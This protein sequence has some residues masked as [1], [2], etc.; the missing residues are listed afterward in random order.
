[1]ANARGCGTVLVVLQG[2][3]SRYFGDF[4]GY[5]F[6]TEQSDQVSGTGHG[7]IVQRGS[8]TVGYK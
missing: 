3:G 2:L 7:D 5:A 8:G 6:L 4:S 1:M